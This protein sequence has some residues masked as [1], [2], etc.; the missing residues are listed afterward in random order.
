[1]S[2]KDIL[3]ELPKLTEEEKRQLWNVLNRELAPDIQE[4]SPELLATVDDVGDLEDP[5]G[6]R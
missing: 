2:I 6:N 4:E 3:E 5:Y 1:M